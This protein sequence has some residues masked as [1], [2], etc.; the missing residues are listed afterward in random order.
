MPEIDEYEIEVL[1]A[2]E[3]GQTQVCC[4]EGRT[5]QVQGRRARHRNQGS[6]SQYSPVVWRPERYSGQSPGGRDALPSADCQR[7]A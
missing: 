6:P 4:N 7:F 2:F 5:C 3:K 1:N